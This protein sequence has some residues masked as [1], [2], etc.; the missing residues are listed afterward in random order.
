MPEDS[1]RQFDRRVFRQSA[2]LFCGL[3]VVLFLL[4]S[5]YVNLYDEGLVLTAAMRTLAGQVLHRDFYYNYGP[6]Q[7]YILAGLF[8]VF[9]PSVLVDRLAIDF[10][11]SGL[12]VSTYIVSRRFCSR[13]VSLITT[14]ACVAWI[15][16]ELLD[17]NLIT[18]TVPAL[19]LWTC[20]LI[21]PVRDIR[22]QR[23][24]AAIAGLFAGISF[25]FRYDMGIGLLA[26]NLVAAA[27]LYWMAERSAVRALSSM[28]RRVLWPYL[29]GFA[30]VVIPA[31]LAFMAAH[32]VHDLLY[33]IVFYSAKYYRF[34]RNLPMP[35]VGLR[36][37][38]ELIFYLMPILM[39]LS[40]W[41]AGR[42]LIQ[43]RR[44][45]RLVEIPAWVNMLL[46]LAVAAFAMYMKSFIRI[47]TS[48]IS[49]STMLCL[50][51]AAILFQHRRTLQ[52][53]VRIPLAITLFVLLVTS[54][55]DAKR[56][57]MPN[58]HLQPVVINWLL[59]P[60]RQ[61]PP[62]Q[63]R[64]WCGF[65][66]PMTRGMCFLMDVDHIQAV[67]YL[68]EHTT[69]ADTLFVGLPHHD[70]IWAN[71]N[72]TYFAAW[73]L[74]STKWSHFDPFLQNRADIQH[75][76]ISEFERN[77]PPYIVL[78][79]EFENIREPN[80]SSVST[81]VHLLDD[82]IAAHYKTVQQYGELT[83]LKLQD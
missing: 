53:W 64:S 60:N 65:K 47:T 36:P 35:R 54:A 38:P 57:L 29:A 28:G 45:A 27:L 74:P 43:R 15:V 12:A 9:G 18:S 71:D 50:I 59:T 1:S 17:L 7:L 8:K 30:V 70:R 5:R 26:A 77:R 52:S 55:A 25:L 41:P 4:N 14:A 67:E 61:P 66:T 19:A 78:D 33:D 23:R 80:G 76:M 31:A 34:A 6:A 46:A 11:A 79:A 81:G 3:Y 82:Y 39:A 40:L 73:R 83:I 24:R 51:I 2:L 44:S 22:V 21:L 42:L 16:G 62:P 13:A 58:R 10:C 49:A 63:Y 48:Q 20:W 72:L 75:E 32:A 69:P 56:K 68:D 37:K